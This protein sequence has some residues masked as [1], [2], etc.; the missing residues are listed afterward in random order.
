MYNLERPTILLF[1]KY[2]QLGWELNR[3]LQTLGNVTAFDYPDIDLSNP[4]CIKPIIEEIRPHVI[5]NATA[6]TAVDKAETEPEIA[7]AV[8]AE[9]PGIMAEYAKKIDA[10]FI[11]FSTDYVFDGRKGSPYKEIDEP[12]PLS[13]YAHSK[14]KG[15]QAVEQIGGAYLIFR[16]SWVYSMRDDNFV[17]KVLRWS[18]EKEELKIVDDQIGNP[19]WARMLAEITAQLLVKGNY[20]ISSWVKGKKGIYHLA[21]SGLTNRY[22]WAKAIL[23]HNLDN[24]KVTEKKLFPVKTDQFPTPAVR[25]LFSALNC[26]FFTNTFMLQLPHWKKALTLAMMNNNFIPS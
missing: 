24:S 7:M 4:V 10:A 12:N 6:Y 19:T 20:D 9:A 8:N 15:E 25:P 18:R 26:E 21:G 14:F 22:E 11:H 3:T 23:T 1:G 16:T 5:L 2:G 13:V 17:T